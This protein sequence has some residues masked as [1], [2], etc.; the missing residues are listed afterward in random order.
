[1]L[2]ELEFDANQRSARLRAELDADLDAATLADLQRRLGQAYVADRL[3]RQVNYVACS[4]GPAGPRL[5]WENLTWLAALLQCGLKLTGLL[6]R[7]E[8]H[9]NDLRIEH[10]EVVLS[11]LPSQFDG[12]RILHLSD[13][14]LD[15]APDEGE[16]LALQ[17]HAQEADLCVMTGDYRFST[18]GAYRA[19]VQATLDIAHRIDCPDGIYGV[20][21]NHDFLEMVPGLESGP[22]RML[23]NESVTIRRDEATLNIVGVDD[24]HYYGTDDLG[25]AGR[26]LVPSACSVLLAHSSELAGAA[27]DA[28]H[29]LYLCGHSHGGQVCLPG[30]TPLIHNARAPRSRIAGPWRRD[31][32][33]GYTSRGTGSSG[34]WARTF[35]PPE[36]TVHVLRC[37]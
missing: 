35:C 23:L 26:E 8:R 30:G 20:L 12:Y 17:L 29:D 15:G 2:A 6:K 37:A 27:A 28:G 7:A 31:G 14:H 36:A 3:G 9:A 24:P 5:Y 10:H 34:L 21:G 32:M 22:M 1:M 16:A 18:T 11:T 19:A 13:L 25:L 4:I 33:Y